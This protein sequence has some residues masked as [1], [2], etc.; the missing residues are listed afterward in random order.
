M[1]TRIRRV[2][3][4]LAFATAVVAAPLGGAAAQSEAGGSD[5]AVIDIQRLLRKAK[6]TVDFTNQIERQRY[7]FCL[8]Q[9]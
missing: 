3:L 2:L 9:R 4:A 7:T 6:A 5:I 1:S 8:G